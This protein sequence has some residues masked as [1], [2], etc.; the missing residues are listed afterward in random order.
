MV[1]CDAGGTEQGS[2]CGM[3]K[4]PTIQYVQYYSQQPKQV[5]L[6][7]KQMFNELVHHV[8]KCSFHTSVFLYLWCYLLKDIQ[9]GLRTFGLLLVL[10]LI[11]RISASRLISLMR[12]F[13]NLIYL[14]LRELSTLSGG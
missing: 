9:Q 3:R 12:L 14:L 10:F 8:Y 13:T 7:P 4:E 1:V 11:V 2:G 6:S 5:V